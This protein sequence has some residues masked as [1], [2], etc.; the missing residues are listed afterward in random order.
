MPLPN[1]VNVR[2]KLDS[3]NDHWHPRLAAEL[4]GQAVKLV[5]FQGAFDFHHHDDEDEMFFVVKGSFTMK[6]RDGDVTIREGE[7]L[8][9]P[10]GVEHCPVADQEVEVM[11][12]EPLTT[13]NTGNL[14]NERTV[15]ASPF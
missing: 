15:E 13:R 4:N 11:L 1:V 7:F 12:F 3:I 8:V 5:K 10:R 14:V 2:E 6:F 9:V